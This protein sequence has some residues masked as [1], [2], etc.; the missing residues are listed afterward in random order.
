[1]SEV[2]SGKQSGAV[3]VERFSSWTAER[4]QQNDWQGY[5]YSGKLMRSEIAAECEFTVSVL[6]QNPAVRAA[7]AK[8]EAEL[9]K[10]GVLPPIAEPVG[11]SVSECDAD[12]A[13]PESRALMAAD[14]RLAMAASKA[15]RRLKAVEEQNA[16]LLAEV[17]ELQRKLKRY[18]L[19]EQHLGETGRLLPP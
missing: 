1:M 3:N 14:G 4:R 12:S 15:E 2:L 10:E 11:D 19:I 18:S 7:L 13:E 6:R 5:V 16:S 9:R 17:R 8:L